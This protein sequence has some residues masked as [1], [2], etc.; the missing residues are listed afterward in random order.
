MNA[1]LST[2]HQLRWAVSVISLCLMFFCTV[3]EAQIAYRNSATASYGSGTTTTIAYVGAGTSD[4]DNNGSVFPRLPTGLAANDLLLCLVESHDTASH[5]IPA[6]WNTLYSRTA[7][8]HHSSLIWRWSVGSGENNASI[9]ISHSGSSIIS[10]CVAFR[11]VST[12]TPFDVIYAAQENPSGLTITSGSF[13]PVSPG[14]MILFSMHHNNNPSAPAS[15]AFGGGVSSWS[16]AFWTST[17][18]GN[19]SA[20][21]LYYGILATPA[22]VPKL[23]ATVGSNQP[24]V[25]T[26]ALI[27]LRPIPAS[28]INLS[29]NVPA[30][31]VAGDTMIATVAVRPSSVSVTGPSGWTLVRSTTQSSGESSRLSTYW[32]TASASDAVGGMSYVWSL[33]GSHTGVVGG[34]SSFGGVD[35]VTPIDAEGGAAT[36]SSL[37]HSTPSIATSYAN[38]MLV[39]AHSYSS[40][41]SWTPNSGQSEAFDLA[42][43]TSSASGITLSVG[44]KIQA[45][46]GSSGA[47]QATA[48]SS[49]DTGAAHVLALHQSIPLICLTDDFESYADGASPTGDWTVTSS[50][51]SPVPVVVASGGSKRLRMTDGEGNRAGAAHLRGKKFPAAGQKIVVEFDHFAYDGSG[52]DGIALAYSDASVTPVAGAYGGSLGYAQ[53][54]GVNGFAGGWIGVGIDEYGN[55]SNPTEGRLD[56]TSGTCTNSGFLPENV[57]IRGSGSGTSGYRFLRGSGTLTPGVDNPLAT[58]PAPG[59]RYKITFDHSN[60]ANAWTTVERDTGSGYQVLIP[61]FDAKSDAS[62]AAVPAEWLLSFTGSTGGATNV[63]EIDNLSVCAASI[64]NAGP[65]HI[66]LEHDGSG[67]VCTREPVT[68]KACADSSCSTLSSTSIT[69]TPAV[70]PGSGS[71]YT[72]ASGGSALSTL[73]IPASSSATFYLSYSS[74][75]AVTLG[76][77]SFSTSPTNGYKCDNTGN[78]TAANNTTECVNTFSSASFTVQEDLSSLVSGTGV[79]V[80]GRAHDFQLTAVKFDGG[81]CGA[82][83]SYAPGSLKVWLSR[84]VADP[85]GT[86]PTI[87]A[88]SLPNSAPGSANIPLTFNATTGIATFSLSTTD[89]GKYTLNFLDDGLTA[90]ATNISGSQTLTVRPFALYVNAAKQGGTSNPKGA[91]DFIAAGDS[92]EATVSAVRWSGTLDANNDGVPDVSPASNPSA[93][94]TQ[95]SSARAASFAAAA[96][97][98][99]DVVTEPASG[100]S[101][102]LSGSGTSIL[103]GGWSSGQAALAANSLA[104]SNVGSFTA[105]ATANNYL[106]LSGALPWVSD[107]IGRFYPYRFG[108][109]AGTG[110][111][112]P[113]CSGGFTYMGQPFAIS[114]TLQ[115]LNKNDVLATNYGTGYGGTLLTPSLV[116]VDSAYAATNLGPRLSSTPSAT[117][118][119]GEYA[120]SGSA[121]VFSRPAIPVPNSGAITN[122]GGPFGSPASATLAVGVAATAPV[123]NQPI[124]NADMFSA[125][126]AQLASGSPTR[127]FF[128]V[129]KLDNAYGSEV[130]GRLSVPAQR[131]YLRA[132]AGSTPLF[133]T[134]TLDTCTAVPTPLAEVAGKTVNLTFA[135]YTQAYNGTTRNVD[136]TWGAAG[137]VAG[138]MDLKANLGTLDWLRGNWT[139][140]NFDQDPTARVRLG[141]A[142]APYIYLRER[143]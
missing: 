22:I 69:L 137:R 19:D 140:G 82:L 136:L 115:A 20:I 35:S 131:R 42:S 50:G 117:W 83:Q 76:A 15:T 125:T 124:K 53:R 93:W 109:K 59:Y 80:A 102:T 96:T 72:A 33:G 28:G 108:I 56:C 1:V 44:Y 135:N 74:P 49:A 119:A 6:G 66:R 70:S 100:G 86:A 122:W 2:E 17:G 24:G 112:T 39:T 9:T 90:S 26:G 79:A 116:L 107:V 84:D 51:G 128:G 37:I 38:G 55:F 110:A 64:V 14:A 123:S 41:S 143:F 45:S 78:G 4:N 23:T 94:A 105:S 88:T 134:N 104:F 114:Y 63:H 62:Q 97:L 127:M 18:S 113:G 21:G 60:N 101:G 57:T 87:G 106:G 98:A 29:V 32:R 10:R 121:V 91:S 129:L 31:T 58:T 5:G 30:T 34:I 7:S 81:A 40:A 25:N 11:G 67:G 8:G 61:R 95:A 73:T 77:G 133:G 27:A 92:F 126:A 48:A 46:A 65:D 52:A 47:I 118:S 43:Q 68:F 54:T 99:A 71:W 3:C 13:A 138:S 132:F 130:L 103:A 16:T 36:A 141:S 139:G 85:A 142:R 89:V 12:T 120:A 111:L 75:L